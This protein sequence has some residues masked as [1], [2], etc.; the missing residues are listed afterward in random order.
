RLSRPVHA[1]AGHVHG[2]AEDGRA[3]A[4]DRLLQ[5]RPLAELVRD[6]ALL[7][8][9][10]R[11]VSEVPRR[12][13]RAVDDRGVPAQ[14]RV[15]YVNRQANRGREEMKRRLPSLAAVFVMACSSVPSNV[16]LPVILHEVAPYTE[17]AVA[18][19]YGGEARIAG[20]V[21]T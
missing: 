19:P 17:R 1:R 20:N 9:A 21:G 6:G 12:R 3:V 11:M 8:R 16:R 7:H 15:R 18:A 5:R 4:A 14:C 2:A 13:W 10:P